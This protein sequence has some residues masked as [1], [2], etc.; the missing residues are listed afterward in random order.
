MRRGRERCPPRSCC[1]AVGFNRPKGTRPAHRAPSLPPNAGR[2]SSGTR[3]THCSLLVF[4]PSSGT[5]KA[6]RVRQ[7]HIRYRPRCS[8][9][10]V[11]TLPPHRRPPTTH[12][13]I[14]LSPA[15]ASTS[16]SRETSSTPNT[17]PPNHRAPLASQC[18]LRP[19]QSLEK[20]RSEKKKKAFGGPHPGAQGEL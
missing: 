6:T 14:P 5:T 19:P 12:Q 15:Q 8:R 3:A 10:Q 11:G 20:R 18:P 4:H 2:K 7:P 17:H 9:T 13:A 16:H 1:E